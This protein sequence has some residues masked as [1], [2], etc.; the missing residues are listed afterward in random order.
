MTVDRPPGCVCDGT[1]TVDYENGY[2]RD[3]WLLVEQRPCPA[4]CHLRAPYIKPEGG[5]FFPPIF[6]PLTAAAPEPGLPST[7]VAS[8]G[9]TAQPSTGGGRR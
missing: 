4:G 2:D 9:A 6:T 5:R 1:G 7:A 8:G 3:G